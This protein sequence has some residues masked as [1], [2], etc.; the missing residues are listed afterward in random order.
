MTTTNQTSEEVLSISSSLL[1]STPFH[2][3]SRLNTFFSSSSLFYCV[4]LEAMKSPVTVNLH[5][6]V[7]SNSNWTVSSIRFSHW[8]S[9]RSAYKCSY[10]LQK[11]EI[12]SLQLDT[13]A[14][15]EPI[16]IENFVMDTTNH[17][18]VSRSRKIKMNV[19]WLKN[20]FCTRRGIVF[21]GLWSLAE[22]GFTYIVI[23]NQ[24]L[25]PPFS[26]KT[27]VRSVRALGQKS[28]SFPAR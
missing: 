7:I 28:P 9:R 20:W 8:S 25:T 15:G 6:S 23:Y 12:R 10:Q 18:I 5:Q 16:T 19:I 2:R 27:G 3:Y 4:I 13:H 1:D 11:F 26:V 22:I 17:T 14:C 24:E 21:H